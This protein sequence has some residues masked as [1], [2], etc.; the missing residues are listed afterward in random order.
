MKAKIEYRGYSQQLEEWIYGS[1]LE[2][3][4][5][6]PTIV[7]SNGDKVEVDRGSVGQFIGKYT[8][9]YSGDKAVRNVYEGDI[10]SCDYP[11]DPEAYIV[12]VQQFGVI[13]VNADHS[14]SLLN[15]A[16]QY[17]IEDF[18]ILGNIFQHPELLVEQNQAAVA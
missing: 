9:D 12:E 1:Y 16:V 8:F 3:D 11:D 5:D 7:C 2:T 4:L 17:I 18:E 15:W 13:E 6:T 14:H 10:I